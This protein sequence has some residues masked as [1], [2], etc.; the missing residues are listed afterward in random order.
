MLPLKDTHRP[1]HLAV[2]GPGDFFGEVGFL[3]RKARTADAL[4]LSD[5]SLYVISRAAFDAISVSNPAVGAAFFQRLAGVEAQR[6]GD[7][8]RELRRL[9]DS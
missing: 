3:T 4:A 5:T 7:A 6:L 9:Q 1:H 2:F 8:D